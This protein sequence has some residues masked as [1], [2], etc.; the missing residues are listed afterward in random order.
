MRESVEIGMQKYSK[1]VKNK[2]VHKDYIATYI[3]NDLY[4]QS[5]QSSKI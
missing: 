3:P 1:C 2:N 5:A 4:R